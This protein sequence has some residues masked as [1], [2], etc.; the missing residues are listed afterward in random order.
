MVG[1]DGALRQLATTLKAATTTTTVRQLLC[2]D[3][4]VCEDSETIEIVRATN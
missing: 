1:V 4:E 2:E 3:S